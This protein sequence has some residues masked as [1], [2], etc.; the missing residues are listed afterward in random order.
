M[1]N[2]I[3]SIL[4]NG[5]ARKS[6]F[7]IALATLVLAIPASIAIAKY[8]PSIALAEDG[9]SNQPTS[10][11]DGFIPVPGNPKFDTEGGF[12]VMKYMAEKGAGNIPVSTGTALP[13]SSINQIDSMN[14]SKVSCNGCHLVTENEWLT[15]ANDIITVDSNWTGGS[16]GN[17]QLY[18]GLTPAPQ[19]ITGG[20]VATKAPSTDDSNGYINTGETTGPSRR[21]FTLSNGEV[22]W[23]LSGQIPE[24]TQGTISQNRIPTFAANE[25]SALNLSN[26][27]DLS[28]KILP[29][30]TNSSASAYTSAQ[31]IGRIRLTYNASPTPL[32][33]LRGSIAAPVAIDTYST[34][35]VT[36]NPLDNGIFSLTA[37]A[38]TAIQVQVSSNYYGTIY[39]PFGFRVAK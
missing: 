39:T 28:P 21:T 20:T 33:F 15:L 14:Y 5:K 36:R 7:R 22:V 37:Q 3:Q 16:V 8:I 34:G 9:A 11:P 17:G 29:S 2:T 30:F 1:S 32:G 35:S 10:C 18:R 19:S 13:W 25:F 12:C 27:G 31:N 38:P 6:L 24:W 26:F 23:D 4:K